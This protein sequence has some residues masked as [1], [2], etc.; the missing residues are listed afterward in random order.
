MA[1]TSLQYIFDE[2]QHQSIRRATSKASFIKVPRLDTPP[3][4]NGWLK[5]LLDMPRPR[6]SACQKVDVD[7]LYRKQ[8]SQQFKKDNDLL[9]RAFAKVKRRQIR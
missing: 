3:R 9:R 6:S 1:N 5:Y 4:F 8:A 2:V 7:E